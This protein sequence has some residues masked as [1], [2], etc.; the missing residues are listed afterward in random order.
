[1]IRAGIPGKAPRWRSSKVGL[2]AE[3]SAMDSPSQPRPLVSHS[4]WMG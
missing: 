2:R 4:T 1:M 3:V